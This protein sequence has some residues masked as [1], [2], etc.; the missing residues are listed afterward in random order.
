MTKDEYSKIKAALPP[1]HPWAPTLM[2]VVFDVALLAAAWA[3]LSHG[4]LLAWSAAQLVLCV[5]YFHAFAL[6]HEAGHGNLHDS[7]RVNDLLGHVF[8]IF[9]FLPYYSWKLIHSEHHIFAG[10]LAKDPA[11]KNLRR[12]RETGKLPPFTKFAWRSWIPLAGFLQQIVFWFYPLDLYRTPGVDP[13]RK[14]RAL[15]SSSFSVLWLLAAYVS[16]GWILHGRLSLISILPSLILYFAMTEMVNLPHHLGTATVEDLGRGGATLA[17]WEQHLTTRSCAYVPE[18]ISQV[19]TL[20]FNY[21]T[22]HHLLPRVS[23][24]QLPEVKRQ[25]LPLL[26]DEYQVARGLSWTIENRQAGLEH[27]VFGS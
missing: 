20:N 10:S 17:P 12:A 9:C 13:R 16:L 25:A 1:S 22:E 3:L 5:F 14:N 24:W 2:V 8:S 11:L 26:G 7:S 21:H 27:V 19:I 23:W 4:G 15:L 18:I 6:L